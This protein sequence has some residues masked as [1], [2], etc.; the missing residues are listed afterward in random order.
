MYAQLTPRLSGCAQYMKD[1]RKSPTTG[2]CNTSGVYGQPNDNLRTYRYNY[3][4][5]WRHILQ[6]DKQRSP[7]WRNGVVDGLYVFPLYGRRFPVVA[8]P[9]CTTDTT[10]DSRA[11]G[12][13]FPTLP[14]VFHHDWGTGDRSLQ[15]RGEGRGAVVRKYIYTGTYIYIL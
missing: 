8:V 9:F 2:A 3:C 12:L 10:G 5:A 7:V 6:K 13:F 15:E 11:I 4:T 14:P 1:N